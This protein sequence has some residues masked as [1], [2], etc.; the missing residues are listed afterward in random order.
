MFLDRRRGKIVEGFGKFAAALREENSGGI[1]FIGRLQSSGHGFLKM[2]LFGEL[3]GARFAFRDVGL[4]LFAF[5]VADFVARV[6]HQKRRNVLATQ[7]FFKNAHRRPPS[8]WRSLRVARKSE[9][10]TVSSVV[11]R[12]SPIARS[13]SP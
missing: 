6:K 9:F 11:P 12:A 3:S 1:E 2:V 4:N 13:L 8:S 5:L 7:T 10:F